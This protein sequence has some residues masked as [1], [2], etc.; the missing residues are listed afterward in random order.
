MFCFEKSTRDWSQV[1]F[2]INSFTKLE[3]QL[4]ENCCQYLLSTAV[5]LLGYLTGRSFTGVSI[6]TPKILQNSLENTC[7]GILYRM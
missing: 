5:M 1:L 3:T 7:D 2:S 4:S 6:A